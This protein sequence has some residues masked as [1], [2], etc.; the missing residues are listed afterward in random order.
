MSLVMLRLVSQPKQITGVPYPSFRHTFAQSNSM[1]PPTCGSWYKGR[2]PQKAR[3]IM[4]TP[5]IPTPP[6]PPEHVYGGF[7]GDINA[8]NTQKL[9]NTLTVA[10]NMGVKN[11]HLLFQ[12]WGGFI[13][14]GVFLYNLFRAFPV[15][16]TL[17]NAG[18]V[19][20]AGVLAFIGAKCRRTTKNGIFMIHKGQSPQIPGTVQK[21]Q[22][23]QQNL[24]LDDARIDAIFRTDLSLPDEVWVQ[25]QHMTSTSPA[26]RRSNI[27]SLKKS[28]SSLRRPIQRSS[29]P[30][31]KQHSHCR[32]F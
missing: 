11:V 5:A 27:R 3:H 23:M 14:D 15:P 29:T 6:P 7:C 19:A 16:I 2:L 28:A 12:S 1:I 8:A 4:A 26:K 9:V 20:S 25:L 31:P 24:I 21:L 22:M 18:Q 30:L 13:G 17:Y 10:S 32:S